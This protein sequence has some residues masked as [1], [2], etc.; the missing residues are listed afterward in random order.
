MPDRDIQLTFRQA[1]E[2][3]PDDA[4]QY[5]HC[6]NIHIEFSDGL[7]TLS[8]PEFVF[9]R[10]CWSLYDVLPDDFPSSKAYCI[11]ELKSVS[12][13]YHLDIGSRI[14]RDY[15]LWSEQ[16]RGIYPNIEPLMERMYRITNDIYNMIDNE[17]DEYTPS[18]SSFDLI[19]LVEHPRI[20][21]ANENIQNVKR[22][23]PSMIGD[24]H[25]EI[26]DVVLNDP[27]L[28]QNPLVI[29]ARCGTIKL[30]QLTM[31]VGP[32][33][34]CTDIDSNIFPEPIR[35]GFYHGMTKMW[36]MAIESRNAAIATLYNDII[37][38]LSEYSN[39]RYQFA[40]QNLQHRVVT[41]CGATDG[42]KV[43]VQNA[44]QLGS[45]AGFW[46]M[47]K[48]GRKV[49][50]IERSDTDLIGQRITH[51][52]VN[53]CRWA[54]ARNT[55]CTTCM[56]L[57]NYSFIDKTIIGHTAAV[58]LGGSTSTIVLQ[59]KH[60]N[61]TSVAAKLVLE[62]HDAQHFTV[63][64]SGR[65]L[66]LNPKMR[67]EEWEMVLA[68]NEALHISDITGPNSDILIPSKV[69]QI[70][71]II[72]RRKDGTSLHK[73]FIGTGARAG[74]LSRFA[75]DFFKTKGWTHELNSNYVF[76]LKGWNRDWLL[77][78]IP[79]VEFTPPEFINNVTSFVLSGSKQD[80]NKTAMSIKHLKHY[81]NVNEA[82][83]GFY[84]LVNSQVKIHSVH[85]Q[86]LILALS[87][88]D[89]SKRDYRLPY[90]RE[91]ARTVELTKLMFFG[92]LGVAM[93]FENQSNILLSAT[94]YLH[95][96]RRPHP[97]DSVLMG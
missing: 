55:I 33:G 8:G 16:E 61:L 18:I 82:Y 80:D 32:I 47:D 56:G 35:V 58:Q 70:S 26:L 20:K 83:A 48:D 79:Q 10:P 19:E 46:L 50:Y 23:I 93:A 41:D 74:C 89:A 37:M 4:W 85:L 28:S 38:P 9:S 87:V 11:S 88:Q 77:L 97:Y 81:T 76:D 94:S 3:A 5:E 49:K 96:Q 63:D 36:Q 13:R 43:L 17:L 71:R 6:D 86:L 62:Y 52:S 40:G 54:G 31:V 2:I 15:V 39:R 75:L 24:V 84:D 95:D 91:F 73:M 78:E 14:L 65:G 21:Q 1:L 7:K 51:R 57:M 66:F 27:A 53:Y 45:L 44:A 60:Q 92:S 68:P 25:K 69:T 90:P 34:Y 22:V 64:D 42:M 67:P 29:A 59:R 30:T 12:V 72:L